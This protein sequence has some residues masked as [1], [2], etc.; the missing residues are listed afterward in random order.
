MVR[1]VDTCP[2]CGNSDM[3]V[4][5]VRGA[6]V[7]ECRLCEARFGDRTVLD[8]LA[9]AEEAAARGVPEAIWPLVRALEALPGLLVREAHDGDVPRGTLPA[10][11]IGAASATALGSLENLAKSLQLGAGGLQ[12]RWRLA[13]EYRRDLVFVLAPVAAAPVTAAALA[14]AHEDL[15][16]LRRNVERDQRLGWWRHAGRPANG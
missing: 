15:G 2:E 4:R 3:R 1:P 9:D 11:A 7:H 5:L 12:C 6:P 16:Q 13:V 14:A 8:E 10:V